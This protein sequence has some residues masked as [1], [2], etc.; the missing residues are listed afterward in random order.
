MAPG[1]WASHGFRIDFAWA[2]RGHPR[3]ATRHSGVRPAKSEPAEY[4][5]KPVVDVEPIPAADERLAFLFDPDA[6]FL[7]VADH[8]GVHLQ[9]RLVH[10]AHRSLDGLLV[11]LDY[12]AAE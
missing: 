2:A 5:D 12:Q 8:E 9:D 1:A 10:K 3:L 7:L 11:N 4:F 6:G